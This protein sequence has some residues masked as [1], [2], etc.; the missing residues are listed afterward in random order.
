[1]A[2]IAGVQ[3]WY[4][5]IPHLL[6]GWLTNW[7]TMIS[8]KFS[9]C[10]EDSEP[11]IRLPSLR[12]QERNWESPGN[13]TLK[14]SRIWCQDFHRTGANRD[15]TLQGHKQ[16]LVCTKT[17]Q[18]VAVPPLETEPD[19]PANV[20]GS[21]VE[22]WLPKGWGHW[23]QE[24]WKV[25]FGVSPLGGHL[26]PYHRASRLHGCITSGQQ[27]GGKPLP[28]AGNWIKAL[29]STALPIRERPSFPHS[30]SFPSGNLHWASSLI[31]QRA[32]RR[33]KKKHNHTA[34]RMKITF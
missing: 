29:L 4:N 30:Q 32:D 23:R 18:K 8:T 6:G 13:L 34:P 16:M 7:R 1:M 3:S 5:Q 2:I 12:I 20:V 21:P 26:Y 19:L 31:Y 24:S 17:Q 11:H 10:C 28:L 14:A 22:A 33:S 15:S 9:H 27:V 25:S